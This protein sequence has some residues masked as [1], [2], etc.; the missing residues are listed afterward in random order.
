MICNNFYLEMSIIVDTKLFEIKSTRIL[1]FKKVKS[2][3]FT[4]E[5]RIIVCKV[6]SMVN[7]F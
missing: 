6:N 3:Q 7:I 2:S 4:V 1:Q 5:S